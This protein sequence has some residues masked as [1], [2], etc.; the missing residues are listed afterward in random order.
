MP[1][2]SYHTTR[3]TPP[4]HL[5]TV[6]VLPVRRACN[7]SR[8]SHT[9][10]KAQPALGTQR[11]IAVD[12]L[13]ML[14]LLPDSVA[15]ATTAHLYLRFSLSQDGRYVKRLRTGSGEPSSCCS[16]T[17]PWR[18]W[19]RLSLDSRSASTAALCRT[20][21]AAVPLLRLVLREVSLMKT[22]YPAKV[23]QTLEQPEITATCHWTTAR[24]TVSK[25]T[26]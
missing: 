24:S 15:S 3:Y 10:T 20:S 23:Q 11:A 8:D 4:L 17:S 19:V 16:C 14:F 22:A 21:T 12:Q 9:E 18:L 25:E 7:R 1:G 13:I 5:L 26:C 6:S 2:K